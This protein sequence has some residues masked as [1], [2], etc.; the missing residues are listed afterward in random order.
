MAAMRVRTEAISVM[1][2]LGVNVSGQE[3]K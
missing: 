3:S 1:S 2:E